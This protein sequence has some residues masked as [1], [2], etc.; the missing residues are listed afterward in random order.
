MDQYLIRVFEGFLDEVDDSGFTVYDFIEYV[1]N[2]Y[3][4]KTPSTGAAGHLCRRS[5]RCKYDADL[6]CYMVIP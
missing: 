2:R 6:R 3:P 5:A 4:K 1:K